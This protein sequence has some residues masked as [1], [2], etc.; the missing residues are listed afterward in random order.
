V[1]TRAASLYE[2]NFGELFAILTR[3]AGKALPDAVAELREAVDFLR[4][5]AARGQEVSQPPR[6]VVGCISPW[7]FPLAIFSGQIAAALAAGNAVVAKP[8]EATSLIAVRA[9]ELMYDAGVP[10]DALQLLP[11]TGAEV[12]AALAA[13]PQVQMMCFTGSTATAQAI[14]RGMADTQPPDA[15]LIAETG[16]LNAMIVDSTALPE[17]AVRDVIMSAFRSAGQRCSALR[18]LYVQDDVAPTFLK[19]LQGAMDELSL[20]NPWLVETDIGPVIDETAKAGIMAHIEAARSEGRMLHQTPGPSQGSFVPPTLIEV[21]GISA[22]KREVFG[23]VLHVARF[24]AAELEHVVEAINATGF[25]L[26]FGIHSR[27]DDRVDVVTR[28]V[29]AGNIYVNRN[30]IGAIVGSQPFGGEGMSGTG[31][32]AGGPKY[33]ARFTRAERVRL[34][35]EDGALIAA[36]AAQAR[37]AQTPQVL[38]QPIS[39]VDLP[40]PTGESNRLT[41]YPRGTV[42]CLGPTLDAARAQ[43]GRARDH[44]ATPIIIAPGASTEEGIDGVLDA[45]V[46]WAEDEALRRARQAL[47]RRA[48]PL[49][50]LISTRDFGEMLQLERHICIDTTAAG[51][52]ARLLA[53][54][55]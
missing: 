35:L 24:K 6:G 36:E 52:N 15:P 12:G 30:Q 45:V 34:P 38:R 7:N 19:M 43:A 1:L 14:H 22:L 21:A 16:G 37:I 5:Y 41:T 2:D 50:P 48:G 18:M 3:E 9:V 11:G 54:A 55:M 47:A 53:E 49:I 39:T 26:T 51:G 17:Q 28:R 20:G 10:R 8:A 33:V 44:G 25:G 31:P 29:R 4:Y 13:H 27:I 40:G 23:P 32:K 46:F 42:L